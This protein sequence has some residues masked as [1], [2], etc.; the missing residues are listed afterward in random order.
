M[1]YNRI[2]LMFIFLSSILFIH[3][4]HSPKK[5]SNNKETK[6]NFHEFTRYYFSQYNYISEEKNK[7][8]SSEMSLIRIKKSDIHSMNLE[9]IYNKMI[10]EK[11]YEVYNDGK[12]KAF[13]IN[14]NNKIAFINFDETRHLLKS[15]D[16]INIDDP[17]KITVTF[18]YNRLGINDCED[19]FNKN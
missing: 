13:C 11:W 6:I 10:N 7:S 18:Y 9:G 1:I 8:F 19:F 14:N 16:Y 4:C 5:D 2:F 3:G 17:S 12:Y 15:G